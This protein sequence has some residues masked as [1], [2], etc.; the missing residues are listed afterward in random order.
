MIPPGN[1][2]ETW[3]RLDQFMLESFVLTCQN[4]FNMIN[5]PT[6]AEGYQVAARDGF[7]KVGPAD[8]EAPPPDG[9]LGLPD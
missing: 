6:F 1:R 5:Y 2:E 8:T 4:N 9:D 7:N 3:R